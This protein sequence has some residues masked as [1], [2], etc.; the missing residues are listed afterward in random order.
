MANRIRP[1]KR[2]SSLSRLASRACLLLIALAV[3]CRSAHLQPREQWTELNIGPFIVDY[4]DDAVAARSALTQLEQLRWVLGG[5]LES[6]DL[7]SVWPFRIILTKG[8]AGAPTIQSTFVSPNFEKANRFVLQ[9]GQYILV[10][11]P[12]EPLP[13]GEV[14]GILLDANTPR[15]PPDVEWGLRQLFST[16]QAHGTHV[17][18]GG[19]PVHPDL[20]WARMQLFATKFEYSLSFHIFL[21]SLRN[22]STVRTAEQNAFGKKAQILESEAA[23]NLAAG[24]WDASSVSGR[25]LDAK[26]DFGEHSADTA[27]IDVYLAVSSGDKAAEKAYKV[28]IESGSPAAPL[29]YTGLAE[30]AK[31]SHEPYKPFLDDAIQAGSRSA[32]VY[33]QAAEG[34][35]GDPALELLKKAAS[36]NPL[37]AEPVYRQAE[38]ASQPAERQALLHKCTELDPRQTECWVA[39]AQSEANSGH[40]EL[41]QGT[42]FRAE[43]SAPTELERNRIHQLRLRSEEQRLDAAD[44]ERRRQQEATQAEEDRA[45]HA[46][47]ARIHAAERK[48]NRQLANESG[49]NSSTAEAIPWNELTS[50]KLRGSITDVACSNDAATLTLRERGGSTTKLLLPD[51]SQLGFSCGVQPHPMRVVVTYA[52]HPDT[53][54]GTAGEIVSLSRQ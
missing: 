38:L 45:I 47:A 17:R 48:A 22:G 1:P 20:A 31:K 43:R 3:Y 46:E 35:S 16:L 11:R 36:L 28:A 29:G 5:L 13:L 54:L 21:T 30:L 19:A 23:G 40:S 10:C 12:D 49:D 41:A 15:L 7:Q 42:W 18:W 25:P 4:R 6:K 26:R 33:V 32:P 8:G 53:Q 2:L 27:V 52:A 44:A 14:A 37:W 34:L 51:R 50:K 9:N 24:H 39:L